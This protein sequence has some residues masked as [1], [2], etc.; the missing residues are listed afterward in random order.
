MTGELAEGPAAYNARERAAESRTGN[1][2]LDDAIDRMVDATEQLKPLGLWWHLKW[3]CDVSYTPAEV[4]IGRQAPTDPRY[5][6][7]LFVRPEDIASSEW[8]GTYAPTPV[9]RCETPQEVSQ[10]QDEIAAVWDEVT[11]LIEYVVISEQSR[12]EHD[13]QKG[14]GA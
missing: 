4:V 1:P 9:R 14:G 3:E 8:R 10:V 2:R 11:R 6:H 5:P 13:G 12:R 7:Q